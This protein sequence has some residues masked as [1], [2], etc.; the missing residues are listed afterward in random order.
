LYT[1]KIRKKMK[2]A[3]V[4]FIQ[5]TKKIINIA[6]FWHVELSSDNICL[7]QEFLIQE[8]NIQGEF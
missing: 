8:Y 1:I 4:D 3:T 6:Y 5:K 2:G 7:I